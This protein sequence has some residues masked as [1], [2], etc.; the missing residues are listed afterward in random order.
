M[1]FSGKQKF[2]FKGTRWVTK[3]IKLKILKKWRW[4]IPNPKYF[5]TDILLWS[6]SALK[7]DY[8]VLSYF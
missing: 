6:I 8:F 3:K 4:V 5:L 7:F 2:E 1:G